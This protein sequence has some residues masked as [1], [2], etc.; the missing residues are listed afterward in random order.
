MLVEIKWPQNLVNA[1]LMYL[2]SSNHDLFLK[3]NQEILVPK[4]NQTLPPSCN[5]EEQPLE[6]CGSAVKGNGKQH[7]LSFGLEDLRN[8]AANILMSQNLRQT[9]TLPLVKRRH[10]WAS[11]RVYLV[12]LQ[13]F[14]LESKIKVDFKTQRHGPLLCLHMKIESLGFLFSLKL[15]KDNNAPV[16]VVNREKQLWFQSLFSY[17]IIFSHFVDGPVKLFKKALQHSF[18]TNILVLDASMLFFSIIE[19]NGGFFYT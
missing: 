17:Y 16:Y 12:C 19:F 14:R 11:P 13:M 18:V 6:R 8:F 10:Q 5:D 9:T 1:S 7:V 2:R 4:P 3:L 15:S